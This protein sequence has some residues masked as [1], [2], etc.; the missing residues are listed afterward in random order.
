MTA[1]APHD[2]DGLPEGVL[3]R[4]RAGSPEAFAAVYHGHAARVYA[5]AL[6]L[7][8]DPTEAAEATQDTFVQVW[9]KL[10]AFRGES[11]LGTWIHR[12]AVRVVLARR[13]GDRRR[14][15][16]V[17]PAA[18]PEMFGTA[19]RPAPVDERLDLDTA[20]QQLPP[21]ARTV[22]VLHEMEG[23]S[24][25]EM[26]ELLGMSEVALRSQLHRARKQLMRTLGR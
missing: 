14:L 15:A 24:Y 6:R 22:F 4:A 2:A 5:T 1:S 8:G 19:A 21:T 17:E 26:R 25:G 9:Q 3:D 10:A 12:I 16:R 18:A 7:V 11:A 23:Y 20:L 13:R